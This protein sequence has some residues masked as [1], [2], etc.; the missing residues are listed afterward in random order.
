VNPPDAVADRL[1]VNRSD[2]VSDQAQMRLP[3]NRPDPVLAEQA[4]AP[5]G[6]PDVS[7]PAPVLRAS[8]LMLRPAAPDRKGGGGSVQIAAAATPQDAQR[9]LGGIKGVMAGLE[10]PP[11]GR[12]EKAV[13][14]GAV[15]Y[16]ALVDGFEDGAAAQSFCASL[17]ST[18]QAC[19]VR[20]R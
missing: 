2:G 13:V 10:T 11:G 4:A 18:G 14:R 17:R 12:V 19:F 3:V 7:T 15:V 9:A 20:A 6:R 1:P 5:P 8:V 16:R